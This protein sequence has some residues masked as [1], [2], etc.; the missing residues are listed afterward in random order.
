MKITHL[1]S[2]HP[3]YDTRIF[4]KMCSSLATKNNHVTL[5]VA[6][7]NGNDLVNNVQ[8][9]DVGKASGNRL[10]RIRQSSKSIFTRALELDAD[11]YHV[12]DPELLPVCLKL[13]RIGKT[14]IF[15]SHEDFPK[16]LLG[17]PYLNWFQRRVLSFAANVYEHVVCRKLDAIIA[18]TPAIKQKFSK[19]NN[20]SVDINNFP[21]L[22]ELALPDS[23]IKRDNTIV[24]VGGI[25][26]IR[27]I[28][29]LVEALATTEG[30]ELN[31]IGEFNENEI[32]DLAR[33]TDGWDK[34]N[35]LG[36]LGREDVAECLAKSA[37]GVVTFLE[38]PNHVESQPNKMFEYMSAGLPVISSNF[39]L[40]KEIIE[41]NDC[42]LCVD[43]QN[44]KEISKAIN[45]LTT[46]KDEAERLGR[47]GKL[48]A[49]RVYNWAAEEAKLLKLYA[50]FV[51]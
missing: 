19:I 29:P 6:D 39:P 42:G 31:L 50:S 23:H 21:I 40:W 8:I 18:A 47:N 30:V 45:Y 12:H 22:G 4:L 5:V 17:K 11:V 48:A 9:V 2:V 34:V 24:Y 13:K 25:S 44:P 3:R 37:A 26:K 33:N 51:E 38:A 27:G 35:E 10:K 49:E 43:P 1:T 28:Q 20:N 36:F 16:Q 46:Y 7:G 41:G 15:D 32:A 14:V